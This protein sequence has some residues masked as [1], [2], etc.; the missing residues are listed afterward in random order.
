MLSV[1]AGLLQSRGRYLP[2]M[3][4]TGS[5]QK[6]RVTVSVRFWLKEIMLDCGR[7]MNLF[8]FSTGSVMSTH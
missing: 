4:P 2:G 6:S 7:E 3:I 1:P 5:K 8:P